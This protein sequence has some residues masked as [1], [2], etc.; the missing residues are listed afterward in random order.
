MVEIKVGYYYREARASTMTLAK[1]TNALIRIV[2]IRN[3]DL[4][5]NKDYVFETIEGDIGVAS[6][7]FTHRSPL[8]QMLVEETTM[9][10][11]VDYKDR[12]KEEIE[13]ILK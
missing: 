5:L 7:R 6:N 12:L 11:L 4:G 1:P 13:E 2:N 8:H 10:E 3:E 9:N